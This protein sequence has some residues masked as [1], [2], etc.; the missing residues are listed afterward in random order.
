[1]R[2]NHEL[3]GLLEE[4]YDELGRTELGR[5][6]ALCWAVGTLL[7]SPDEEYKLKRYMFKHAPSEKTLMKYWF[8]VHDR[9]SRYAWLREHRE[10]TKPKKRT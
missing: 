7:I 9:R 8:P 2:T 4:K 5:K 10:R 6:M 3:L 1:M